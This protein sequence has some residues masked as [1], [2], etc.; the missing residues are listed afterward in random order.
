MKK[1]VIIGGEGHG[2]EI[3]SVIKDNQLFYG[4]QLWDIK[5]F[6]NDYETSVGGYPV[7]GDITTETIQ[8]LCNEDYYFAWGFHL[9]GRNPLTYEIFERLS[10]PLNRLVTTI[11]HSAFI[12]E[13][14]EL[15]AG[16]TIM[17]HTYIC[18]RVKLG[19][20]TIVKPNA[21]LGHDV[22]SGPLCHF[23][24]GSI[25]GSY[26]KVGICSDIAI[27]ATTLEHLSIGD[28]SMAAAKSLI[29]K[30]IPSC[31]IHAGIPAKYFREIRKD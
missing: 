27:G 2:N 23:A 7:I 10:I 19:V 18:P 4:N 17:A 9:I 8:R 24:M 13:N 30:N 3:T 14:V 20:G 25:T 28:F 1:L 22:E 6:L 26:T 16:V 21:C 15:S 11:H 29:T 12:G 5:G 31:E